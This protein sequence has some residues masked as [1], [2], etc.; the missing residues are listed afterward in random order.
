MVGT[1]H[2][3]TSRL[4]LAPTIESSRGQ[5]EKPNFRTLI[6]G[7]NGAGDVRAQR[8]M[9]LSALTVEVDRAR[10]ARYGLNASNALAV[11]ATIGGRTVGTVF[12]DDSSETPI[13]VR[14]PPEARTDAARIGA[15]PVGMSNGQ[16]VPLSDVATIT[17]AD[18]PS[19]IL[20]DK[21]KRRIDVEI[22]VDGR[23]VAS[24]VADAQ[25]AVGQQVKL[26]E[27]YTVEWSGKFQNLQSASRGWRWWCRWCWR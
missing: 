6:K 1:T 4:Q 5:P 8:L 9:G 10:L 3:M 19:Q 16:S 11:V 26:P 2:S 24:Y 22:S 27:G 23:D 18:G 17:M 13:V 12:G 7:I 20:R 25:K 21:L 15:L 14:L